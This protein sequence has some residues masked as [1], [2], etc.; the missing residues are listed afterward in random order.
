ME[1]NCTRV[2]KNK[3]ESCGCN[4]CSL[5][6]THGC[7]SL[8]DFRRQKGQSVSNLQRQK[9]QSVGNLRSQK[10]QSV[11]RV[12]SF[13]ASFVKSQSSSLNIASENAKTVED[14]KT[15]VNEKRNSRLE[16][17]ISRLEEILR[18]P[19]IENL[20]KEDMYVLLDK[21]HE[22]NPRLIS[23]WIYKKISH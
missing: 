13:P 6:I 10:S 1:N 23:K 18:V 8:L 14:I 3:S 22:K 19:R 2:G 21:I 4:N 20:N 9:S 16:K 11:R 5:Q 7:I 12:V 15:T 17:R